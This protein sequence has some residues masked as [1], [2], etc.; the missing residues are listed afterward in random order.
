[1]KITYERSENALLPEGKWK[2][3][4]KGHVT[5][6]VLAKLLPGLSLTD[7]VPVPETLTQFK[8]KSKK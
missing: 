7:I 4:C 5:Q 6:G 8:Q 3:Q 1:M 2:Y